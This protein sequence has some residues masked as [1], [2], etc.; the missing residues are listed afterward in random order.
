MIPPKSETARMSSPILE[1]KAK[2]YKKKFRLI[3]VGL[4]IIKK[5]ATKQ[6]FTRR[7]VSQKNLGNQNDS[8]EL[9]T[10]GEL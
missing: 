6:I 5:L 8:F 7:P 10:Q 3:N 9:E 1:G 2:G 4:P